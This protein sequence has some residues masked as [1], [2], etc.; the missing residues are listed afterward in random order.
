MFVKDQA[1]LCVNRN[2]LPLSPLLHVIPHLTR[3]LPLPRDPSPVITPLD[4]RN[5]RATP[6]FLPL[7]KTKFLLLLLTSILLL[8]LLLLLFPTAEGTI[9]ATVL[10]LLPI[11]TVTPHPAI[12]RLLLIHVTTELIPAI[13]RL[14]LIHVTTELI[15]AIIRLLLIHVITEL[16]PAIIPLPPIHVITEPIPAIIPLLLIHV[17]TEPTPMIEFHT[18]EEHKHKHK[19]KHPTI[20]PSPAGIPA[21][22]PIPAVIPGVHRAGPPSAALPRNR[23]VPAG[24]SRA[25]SPRDRIPRR[26]RW[27]EVRVREGWRVPAG[28]VMRFRTAA[29][30]TCAR[31][32]GKWCRR[33]RSA[34]WRR[35]TA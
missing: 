31:R 34:R 22:R 16:I 28:I 17:T 30:K 27:A 26:I 29:W 11:P 2:P 3:L 13:I 12:I 23:R 5:H 21:P 4:P 1:R 8:L 25:T 35:R 10:L 9:H 33:R 20:P 19:H 7:Q 6:P 18:I 15:P 24:T 32:T 14:L